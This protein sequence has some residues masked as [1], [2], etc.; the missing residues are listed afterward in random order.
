MSPLTLLGTAIAAPVTTGVAGLLLPR[1]AIRARVA[2]SLAGPVVSLLC[3]GLFIHRMGVDSPALS[4]AWMPGLQLNVGLH[5]DRLGLFFALLVSGIGLLITLY[6]RAYFGP[7]QDNL[8]RFYPSLHLFMTAM[9]G[10]ALADNLV[11]L[12]LFWE[13]TSISSF[14]LIGWER[15]DPAAVKKAMQAFIVTG[16]GGLALMAGLILM[17]SHT[18][19]WSFSALAHA[20]HAHAIEPGPMLTAAFV[21]MFVGAAAK[22]AQWPLHFWLPGAMAAPTPVSAYLHSATMVKAGVY[23]TGRLW[24]IF[25]GVGGFELWPALIIPIGAITMVYGAFVALQKWDLKQIFAYTTVS[26]LGLL[27]TMYGLSWLRVGHGEHGELNAMWDVTQILNHALYKAPL[28]ILAGA[29]GHVAATRELP[30]LRGLLYRGRTERILT[31]L[32]LLA[33]YA[34]AAGP[35]TLSFTA[36]E[37][38]FYQLWH[39]YEATH[40]LVFGALLLAGIATGMFNVAIFIRLARV[41]CSRAGNERHGPTEDEAYDSEGEENINKLA[42]LPADT[43][44]TLQQMASRQHGEKVEVQSLADAH[45]ATP[46]DSHGVPLHTP[47]PAHAHAAGHGHGAHPHEGGLWPAFLWIP[48]LVIVAFQYISGIIPGAHAY[49]FGWLERPESLTYHFDAV[50][51]F[52]MTWDALHHPSVPLAMSGICIVLGVTLGFAQVFR[53]VWSD[54]HDGL[55]PGFYTLATRGGGRVFGL[56]QTGHASY[57]I[58][59]VSLAI[60]FAFL[61]GI[62]FNLLVLVDLPADAW[63]SAVGELGTFP[64]MIP[65]YLWITLVC[66][67]TLLMP[68]V[69]DRPSRVLVLGACGFS[70]TGIYYIY[71]APDLALTQISIEIISLILFLLVLS[72]LPREKAG[73]NRW[74]LS[75]ALLSCAVGLVMAWLTLA[76][77]LTPQPWMSPTFYKEGGGRFANLGEFFLRNS[78]HGVDTLYVPLDQV[79]GGVVD[80]GEQHRDGFGSSHELHPENPPSATLH[81]G[82]GGNNVVN[83]ILVDG[84]GFDTMGEI[85]VL[86][87]AAIGVWLLLKR[88]LPPEARPKRKKQ[89]TRPV[90]QKV[91][92]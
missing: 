22:S 28:F 4:L 52:P 69:K 11:L 17:G 5:A 60:V 46:M 31:V 23:L 33:A 62:G 85:T 36:K 88:H 6:A 44:L 7:D 12:L 2:L 48:G 16:M 27:M 79:Y 61:W 66:V 71:Q 29:I 51:K 58:A 19:L 82:G 73:P 35:L 45:G 9:I 10:V 15:D 76:S 1:A 26:Q 43:N 8:Y 84:R 53:K 25:V 74:V 81:K 30:E 87:L 24:P 47:G 32:L 65:G 55:Y 57:Y 68:V 67:T 14:L 77:A 70:V 38:F 42:G 49:L 34:L 56:L 37:F 3:L 54:P 80:R 63:S 89:P 50:S 72:L 90:A 21:L 59:L 20:A 78:H 39:A 83:V 40:S 91:V 18:G 41:L 92:T 75:R 13:M 86:G 64:D